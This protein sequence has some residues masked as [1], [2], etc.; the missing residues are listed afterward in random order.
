MLRGDFNSVSSTEERIG[1]RV[2]YGGS[3]IEDFRSFIED[4]NLID[5]LSIGGDYTW[6]SGVRTTMSRL[7]K[8]SLYANMVSM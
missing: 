2:S 4:M 7:D 5:V 6:F 1:I 3:E 8:I